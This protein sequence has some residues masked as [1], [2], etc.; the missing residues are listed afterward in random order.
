MG[1][2]FRKSMKIAPGVRMNLSTKGVGMSVGGKGLRV[3]TSSRGVSVGA[4]IPG[5]GLSYQKRLSSTQNNRNHVQV[6]Y[7]GVQVEEYEAYIASITHLHEDAL[8]P[9]DWPGIRDTLPPFS[10]GED[11]PRVVEAKQKLASFE[12]NW[13]DRLFKRIEARQ[14]KMQKELTD[15]QKVDDASYAEWVAKTSLAQNVL[16]GDRDAWISALERHHIFTIFD[17]LGNDIAFTILDNESVLVDLTI[18]VDPIPEN[19][20]SLTK[21]GKLS[22]RK[23]AKGKYLQLLQDYV[24]SSVLRI[25]LDLIHCLPVE[26]VVVNVLGESQAEEGASGCLLSVSLNRTGLL[27]LTETSPSTLIETFHPNM[28][29][30]KTKGFK[31]VEKWH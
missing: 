20:L 3:N 14:A 11:G 8:Q 28:K 21:T 26:N 25:G 15:S 18:N 16:N 5:T 10:Q 24:C 19:A 31:L 13:I 9:V 6:Q 22:S 29:F 17:E 12:P 1:F 30:L 2:R 4:S 7:N 23:M 27:N